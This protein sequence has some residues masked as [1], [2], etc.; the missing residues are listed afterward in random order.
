[1]LEQSRLSGDSWLLLENFENCGES[2]RILLKN[3]TKHNVD[4]HSNYR[5]WISTRENE[6]FPLLCLRESLKLSSEMSDC[7]RDLLLNHYKSGLIKDLV[8]GEFQFICTV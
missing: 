4:F 8:Q 5:L 7:I 2:H 3:H 6:D 1:M